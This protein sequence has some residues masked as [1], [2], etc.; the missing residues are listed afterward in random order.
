VF[1]EVSCQGFPMFTRT[2][3]I[4]NESGGP[5]TSALKRLYFSP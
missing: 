3:G 5:W 4:H 2:R 1:G